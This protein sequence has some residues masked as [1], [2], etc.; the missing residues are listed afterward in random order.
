LTDDIDAE[1]AP[2][3]DTNHRKTEQG[4]AYGSTA[5]ENLPAP[6]EDEGLSESSSNTAEDSSGGV[7]YRSGGLK[8]PWLPQNLGSAARILPALYN[9]LWISAMASCMAPYLPPL[10]TS[11][12]IEAWEYGLIFSAFTVSSLPGSVLAGILTKRVT[13]RASYFVG[14]IG[15][16]VFCFLFGTLYW[17]EDRS[18]FLG[19]AISSTIFGGIMMS[20]YNI[21]IYSF[22]TATFHRKEGLLIGSIECIGGVGGILGQVIGG[23]L[24]DLWNFSLPFYVFGVLLIFSVPAMAVISK[25]KA[26]V[27]GRHLQ[28]YIESEDHDI[29]T[30]GHSASCYRLLRDPIFV[31]NMGTFI[32]GWCIDSFNGPTLQPYLTQFNLSNVQV[33]SVFTAKSV[34]YSAGAV[35]A[36][37]FSTYKVDGVYMIVGELLV[38]AALCIMGPAPFVPL[39]PNLRLIYA[40]QTLLGIGSAAMFTCSYARA[41]RYVVGRAGYPDTSRTRDFVSTTFYQFTIIGTVGT[42]PLAGFLVSTYGYRQASMVTFGALLIWMF[43]AG[44]LWLRTACR[45]IATKSSGYEVLSDESETITAT[46]ESPLPKQEQGQSNSAFYV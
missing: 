42:P 6:D 45:N 1:V 20:T 23:S 18:L 15:M 3:W 17:A 22:L 24:V 29:A 33:G 27:K 34:G 40:G 7:S 25:K 12:S 5:Q 4:S 30:Q 44:G 36:G 26:T 46:K 32:L 8:P 43:I 16:A 37:I 14:H 13:P 31:A 38:A 28:L 9:Q 10:A 21:S 11:R 39:K 35:I 2:I 41:L 19:L